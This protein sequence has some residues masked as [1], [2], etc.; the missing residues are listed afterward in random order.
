MNSLPKLQFPIEPYVLQPDV[1][2]FGTRV[3]SRI[4]LW[5]R[6]LGDDIVASPGTLVSAIGEGE[7]VWAEVRAGSKEKRNWGGL[8]VLKHEHE[9]PNAEIPMTETFYSVYGH[10]THI[11]VKVG[12]RVRV[13]EKLGE[14][15]PGLTPENG[16]WKI[17]HLHFAIYVGNWSG[18]ILPGYKRFFDGRTKMAWWR[19]PKTFIEE[20]NKS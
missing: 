16:W 19:D 8:I 1:Y 13:G 5:A 14:V 11:A 10:I 6:H 17:P 2:R 4:I 7:V 15:A 18:E 12:E 9:N 20:H 3:R